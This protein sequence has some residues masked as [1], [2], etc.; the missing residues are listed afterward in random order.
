[1]VCLFGDLFYECNSSTKK[2]G[3]AGA[4]IRNLKPAKNPGKLILC[5]LLRENYWPIKTQLQM[6]I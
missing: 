4:T 5:Q 1:M 3:T 6:L 2:R